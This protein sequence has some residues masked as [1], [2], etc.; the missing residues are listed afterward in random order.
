MKNN[1]CKY[2]IIL[3]MSVSEMDECSICL[4]TAKLIPLPCKHSFCL[5]CLV[6]WYGNPFIYMTNMTTCP[7]CRTKPDRYNGVSIR[8]FL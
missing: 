3:K 5:E 4:E 6:K 2:E 8:L 1:A 7:T